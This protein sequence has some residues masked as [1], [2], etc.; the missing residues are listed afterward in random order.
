MAGV[1][2][3]STRKEAVS[4]GGCPF[5]PA[6]YGRTHKSKRKRQ[7]EGGSKG[8]QSPWVMTPGGG[9]EHRATQTMSRNP[10]CVLSHVWLFVTPWTVA[11]QA[12]LF[13]EF[14]RQEYWSGLP[15]P[16]AGDFPNS[17]VELGFL[18]SPSLAGRFSTTCATWEARRNP[19]T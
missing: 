11:C 5:P 7:L 9:L 19:G 17:G 2:I 3:F 10:M 6:G 13:M 15:H 14:P 12:P 1:P 4:W 8:Q 18:A 16:S